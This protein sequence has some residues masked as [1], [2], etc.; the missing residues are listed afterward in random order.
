MLWWTLRQLKSKDDATRDRALKKL[1]SKQAVGDLIRILKHQDS[2]LRAS[3][4]MAGT[5]EPLGNKTVAAQLGA[6]NA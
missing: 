5:F 6:M 3:A 4:A 2:S 1:I